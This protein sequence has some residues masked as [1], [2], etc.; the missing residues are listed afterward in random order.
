MSRTNN[1]RESRY[2]T[3]DDRE[4][5]EIKNKERLQ[6]FQKSKRLKKRLSQ[7]LFAGAVGVI[8]VIF[9]IICFSVFFRISEIEVISSPK[10]SKEQILSL[11]GIEEG[12]S[13]FEVSDSDLDVLYG[14]LAYVSGARL[15]R[16]FPDTVIIE[17]FEDEGRYVS[18]LYGE[19]FVLSEELRVLDR[20][21]DP[22]ELEGEDLVELV[23]PGINSAVVGYTVEFENDISWEYVTAYVD[24]LEASPLVRKATAFD[25][26]DRFELV[27]IADG[28]YL[29][30]FG[31]GDELPTKLTVVAGMLEDAYF[32]DGIPATIDAT[33]PSECHVIKNQSVVVSFE[34]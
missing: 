9:I 23:L 3:G 18:E 2:F 5:Q 19:Y 10:Y 24:A 25:L 8:A 21:F 32:A 6:R 34:A 11:T 14:D 26:R 30:N 28:R 31:S 16:K 7:F 1:E 4:L 33:D 13:L 29:V 22:A 17:L 20:V 27:M 15:T 12:M